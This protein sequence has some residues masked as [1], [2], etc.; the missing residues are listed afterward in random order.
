VTAIRHD[1]ELQA[2]DA[3]ILAG[4]FGTRLRPVLSDR[5]KPLAPVKDRPFIAF[6]LDQIADADLHY[7]VLCTGYLGDQLRNALGNTYKSLEIAYSCEP[8]ALGTAGAL[9]LAVDRFRSNTV[10]V[11]NGDSYCD[12]DMNAFCRWHHLQQAS[13]SIV[14]TRVENADRFGSVDTNPD[15][16]IVRFGEKATYPTEGW[17]N[18]GIY[19]IARPLIEQIPTQRPVSLERDIFPQ[20]I[21]SGFYGYRHHGVFLDIGTPDSYVEAARLFTAKGML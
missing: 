9:R 17:V 19:L 12:V 10:L 20:W 8:A 2:L 14:L 7:V 21:G 13:A 3:A 11:L 1:S 15:G 18:A 6:L 16:T 5:P 4:G